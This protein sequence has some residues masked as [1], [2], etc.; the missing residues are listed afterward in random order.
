MPA[1]KDISAHHDEIRALY[2]EKG[3]TCSDI[4]FRLCNQ[5][6]QV[7]RGKIMSTLKK[8]GVLRPIST[9]ACL[10]L[11]KAK[12]AHTSQRS[13]LHCRESYQATNPTQKHCRVC[14]PDSDAVVR[15]RRYKINQAEYEKLLGNQGNRCAICD[16]D[17]RDKRSHI[18]HCHNTG[19]VRGVLCASCNH[20]LAYIERPGFVESARDY[21]ESR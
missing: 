4:A 8:L 13:C 17:L 16:C 10:N 9:S 14:A 12:R 7:S 3:M 11:E 2:L 20:A 19:K 18:D 21:L 1:F 6:V 15:I 5:G